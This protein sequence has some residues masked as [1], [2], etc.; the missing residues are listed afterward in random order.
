MKETSKS[1]LLDGGNWLWRLFFLQAFKV[2]IKGNQKTFEMKD[3]WKVDSRFKYQQNYQ[4]LRT[5]YQKRKDKIS[6]FWILTGYI[7]P[8]LLVQVLASFTAQMILIVVPYILRLIIG[9]L[10]TISQQVSQQKG[11]DFKYCLFSLFDYL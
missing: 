5:Y 11:S 6:L 8:T 7:L 10:E 1:K 3:L 2:L 9:Q 4:K